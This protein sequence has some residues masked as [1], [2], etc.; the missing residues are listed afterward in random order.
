MKRLLT[1][2]CF[3]LCFGAAEANPF[4]LP[5]KE[6][7]FTAVSPVFGYDPAYGTLLGFAWFSYPTGEVTQAQTRRNLSLVMRFGANG[8]LTYQQEKPNAS[9]H[10]GWDYGFSL[11]NFFDYQT[12]ERST[13]ILETY[14][15][16]TLSATTKARRKLHDH[17]EWYLGPSFHWQWHEQQPD[18]AEGYLF[19][20]LTLDHRDDPVNG[21]RGW[22]A[23]A[24]MR[25]Q[26][27]GLNNQLDTSSSQLRLESRVFLPLSAQ[28]TL[29]LRT[30][31]ETALGEGLISEAGGSELLRGYL[32]S[33]FEAETMA[34][35][36]VEYRFPIWRFIKGVGFAESVHLFDGTSVSQYQSAGGGFRFG[37]P[38]DQSMSVRWDIAVNDQGQWQTFVNFNQVF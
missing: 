15:Q 8:A 21:H 7:Y 17:V 26:P 14:D 29:A 31:A 20:G 32:T 10:W 19:S 6:P 23:N 27:A 35:A 4:G 24:E 3:I 1:T 30:M 12:A 11:N 33:Q 37:L 13:D 25:Y 2:L 16:L 34:A 9:A 5:Q 36:Q 18:V 28:Q 22:M 38:P